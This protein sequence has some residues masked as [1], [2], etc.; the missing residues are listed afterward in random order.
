VI[1]VGGMNGRTSTQTFSGRI[2]H[3][4]GVV[5]DQGLA[6]MRS[7]RWVAAVAE[8]EGRIRHQHDVDVAA[9]IE[10]AESPRLK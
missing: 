6:L 4:S 3:R 10:D 1:I 5:H 7:R 8:I 2:A 9:E